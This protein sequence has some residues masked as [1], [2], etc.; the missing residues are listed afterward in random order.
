M[1]PMLLYF[2]FMQMTSNGLESYLHMVAD[3]DKILRE[4]RSIQDRDNLQRE[5]HR[6]QYW[7]DDIISGNEPTP[8]FDVKEA[9]YRNLRAKETLGLTQ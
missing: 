9:K 8:G 6:L 2:L 4:V 7:S 5:V 3:E 1:G